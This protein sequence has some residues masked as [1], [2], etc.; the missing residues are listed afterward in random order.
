MEKGQNPSQQ[1]KVV[2]KRDPNGN[3]PVYEQKQLPHESDLAFMR[4]QVDDLK[5]KFKKG[6]IDF[7]DYDMQCKKL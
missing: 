5:N 1:P 4:L 6:R 2:K 7:E 3:Y